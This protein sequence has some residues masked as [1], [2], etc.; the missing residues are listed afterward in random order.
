MKKKKLKNDEQLNES[1]SSSKKKDDET[2]A[3]I[4]LSIRNGASVHQIAKAYSLTI[5][6]AHRFID[7]VSK[8][9]RDGAAQHRIILRSMLRERIPEAVKVLVE[10]STGTI[11]LADNHDLQIA[12]LR[13]KAADKLIQ[14][15]SRFL[16]EDIPTSAVEQG[17]AEEMIQT[18]F[19]FES[20]VTD[21]GATT[22]VAKP[23][24]RLVENE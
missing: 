17:K 7:E 5:E 10:I 24:L 9:T 18:I 21:D 6:D 22:L 23:S 15:G 19:D 3:Q 11:S 1:G 14:Y 13:F 2:L 8:D 12:N 16:I 20:V 4:I